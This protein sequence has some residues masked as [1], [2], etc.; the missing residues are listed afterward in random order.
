MKA[1]VSSVSL[2]SSFVVAEGVEL[3]ESGSERVIF[4][5]YS[6]QSLIPADIDGDGDLDFF[7]RSGGYSSGNGGFSW[8][9]NDG[10][11]SFTS[12]DIYRGA[13]YNYR[14]VSGDFDGD[15]VV[16]LATYTDEWEN[17]NSTVGLELQWHRND[18][19]GSFSIA[20]TILSIMGLDEW[21][22]NGDL[23]MI[24]I[25]VADLNNDN[26]VD[27]LTAFTRQNYSQRYESDDNP[28]DDMNNGGRY[29]DYYLDE[30]FIVVNESAALTTVAATP[31]AD[32]AH[33]LIDVTNTSAWEY[34]NN[35][36]FYYGE[37][38][39]NPKIQRMAYGDFDKNGLTDIVYGFAAEGSSN[40]V[41]LVVLFNRGSS[42]WEQVELFSR[43][44]ESSYGWS[45]TNFRAIEV[46]DV[47]GDGE[48][49]IVASYSDWEQTRL[50]WWRSDGAG[51]FTY[52]NIREENPDSVELS[53]G[54]ND[55]W[56]LDIDDDQ[57]NDVIT[58]SS[59]DWL[60]KASYNAN[61][62]TFTDEPL[63]KLYDGNSY[64]DSVA[65]VDIDQ[66]GDYDVVYTKDNEHEVAWLENKLY[67]GGTRAPTSPPSRAPT[68]PPSSNDGNGNGDDEGEE[69][70]EDEGGNGDSGGDEDEDEIME[71][72]I[73]FA[74]SLVLNCIC[75]SGA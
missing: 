32:G 7:L 5:A 39:Y 21:G 69:E 40:L 26:Q 46:G 72:L 67:N 34:E 9:E 55:I 14:M 24:D 48:D 13:R 18:G 45:Y 47:D 56:I 23:T 20:E 71:M 50:D 28:V 25:L 57:K 27:L 64:S 70:D 11:M 1:I 3:F 2:L 37:R 68:S 36:N 59:Y 60:Y 54:G 35:N 63:V 52:G 75:I 19:I 42:G 74:V 10:S 61:D 65:I 8:L 49:D 15:G 12:H 6:P 44:L 22:Y 53:V 29:I 31:F 66:D 17:A 16:D 51:G 30:S 43:V 73:L 41:G 62:G 38:W 33:Y 4:P 58:S